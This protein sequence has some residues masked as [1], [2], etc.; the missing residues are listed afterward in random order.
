MQTFE[1]FSDQ[2]HSQV[3]SQKKQH[4]TQRRLNATEPHELARICHPE[5]NV[6]DRAYLALL[7]RRSLAR[8]L[9]TAVSLLKVAQN[10][11]I[12][13][14][15]IIENLLQR[16][17]SETCFWLAKAK[18][19]LYQNAFKTPQIK[20]FKNKTLDTCFERLNS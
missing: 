13:L 2:R 3:T 10:T 11:E 20:S 1:G 7:L 17:W 5:R 9:F 4:V 6:N 19:Y 8:R 15:P 18:A 16:A 14:R 12:W